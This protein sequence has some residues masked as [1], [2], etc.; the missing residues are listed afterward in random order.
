MK[1]I[2]TTMILGLVALAPTVKAEVIQ[3]DTGRFCPRNQVVKN[4]EGKYIERIFIAAEGIRNSGWIHVWADGVKVQRIGVPGYDPDYTFRVRRHVQEIRLTFEST[5]SRIF[6]FKIFSPIEESAPRTRYNRQRALDTSWGA[7]VMTLIDD[8]D[9]SLVSDSLNIDPLYGS[10]L[11]PLKRIAMSERASENERNIRRLTKSLKAL[12]MA[13][14]IRDNED[15]MFH[16]LDLTQYEYIISDL[17]SIKE[18]ILEHTDVRE[19][20]LDETIEFLKEEL[21]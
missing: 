19:R 9:Q 17:L 12:E 14:I 8:I 7:E 4:V 6:D 11:R 1:K 21:E 20:D 3:G 18:D 15:Y 2:M 16:R 13:K 5:C 10:V